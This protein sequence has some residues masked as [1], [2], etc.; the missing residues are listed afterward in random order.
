MNF[1]TL[2]SLKN[3]EPKNFKLF[4]T[5]AKFDIRSFGRQLSSSPALP[6]LIE[7]IFTKNETKPIH[8][9]HKLLLKMLMTTY[10]LR[11]AFGSQTLERAILEFSET[12]TDV[13]LKYLCISSLEPNGRK[14]LRN[15]NG[16]ELILNEF[17]ADFNSQSFLVVKNLRHFKHDVR[18][19]AAICRHENFLDKILMLLREH[20]VDPRNA[21]CELPQTKQVLRPDSPNFLLHLSEL[22]DQGQNAYFVS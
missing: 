2:E 20:C 6:K 9:W 14:T 13:L 22:E 17:N 16:L 4:E 5:I 11:D 7:L 15:T 3:E 10:Q 12:K 18:G 1:L 21:K 19:L 8:N